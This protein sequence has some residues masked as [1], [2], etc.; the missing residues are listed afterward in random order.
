MQNRLA[1]AGFNS[2]EWLFTG[3]MIGNSGD[4]QVDVVVRQVGNAKPI[5]QRKSK[6][7]FANLIVV[8]GREYRWNY[9]SASR[10]D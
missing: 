7:L 10:E 6:V 1:N 9:S 8:R 2:G 3:M 5:K 4:T